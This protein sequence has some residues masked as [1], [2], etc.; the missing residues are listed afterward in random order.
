MRQSLID[1]ITL[2][3]TY[4]I[5]EKNPNPKLKRWE[6]GTENVVADALSQQIIKTSSMDTE[7][8]AES[9]ASYI[10]KTV[11]QVYN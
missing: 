4:A 3:I 11:T 8:S 9:S 6:P 1:W 5:P 7:H 10:I 2:I